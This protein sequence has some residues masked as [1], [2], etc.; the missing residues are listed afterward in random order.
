MAQVMLPKRR[1]VMSPGSPMT[2][3]VCLFTGGF[4]PCP[5]DMNGLKTGKRSVKN[6]MIC[7]LNILIRTCMIRRSGHVRQKPSG[8]EICG[9]DHKTP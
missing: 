9:H 1:R 7:I 4:M 6:I 2:V 5:P 8:N 3:S